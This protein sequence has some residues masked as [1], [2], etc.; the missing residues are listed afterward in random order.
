M[1]SA[2]HQLCPRYSGA[3]T[4][5]APTAIRLWDTFTFYIL[6]L[7]T[8]ILHFLKL[9]YKESNLQDEPPWSNVATPQTGSLTC[10]WDVSPCIGEVG[11]GSIVYHQIQR[12][13]HLFHVILQLTFIKYVIYVRTLKF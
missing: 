3:L 9:K 6:N 10:T 7:E 11:V 8:K 13:V 5:T 2:F 4:P 1:G 12:T